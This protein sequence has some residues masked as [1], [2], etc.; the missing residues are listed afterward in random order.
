MVLNAQAQ[1]ALTAPGSDVTA[2]R[3]LF[4]ELLVRPDNIQHLAELIAGSD[5]RYAMGGTD[6]HPLVGRFVPDLDLRLPTGET[7]RLAEL[8]R[9]ARPLLLDLTEGAVLAEELRPW[10][11]RVDPVTAQPH[12]PA[13]A[14]TALLLRP[15]CYV[16]WAS[17]SPR[18]DPADLDALRT[19]AQQWFGP[20]RCTVPWPS[21]RH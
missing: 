1:A 7:A 2:L 16:A 10:L 3:E 21:T 14:F 15:D 19:A 13:P 8:I 20:G 12:S 11:D 9:T 4:A 6:A 17:A 18:P 5:V